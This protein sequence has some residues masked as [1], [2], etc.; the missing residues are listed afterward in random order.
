LAQLYWQNSPKP[1]SITLPKRLSKIGKTA[2]LD[3]SDET[4]ENELKSTAELPSKP[5]LNIRIEK[6]S[7]HSEDSA[8]NDISADIES[9][10]GIPKS[11]TLFISGVSI[12]RTPETKSPVSGRQLRSSSLT[13]PKYMLKPLYKGTSADNLTSCKECNIVHT[14]KAHSYQTLFNE[15]RMCASANMA[16][17]NRCVFTFPKSMTDGELF[18]TLHIDRNKLSSDDFHES[19]FLL[20]Q[21]HRQH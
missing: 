1:S 13:V 2:A 9:D 4:L 10:T 20:R 18:S 16:D 8:D 17:K 11:P 19:L 3:M 15:E 21:K 5:E 14:N 6:F 12:N 7:S